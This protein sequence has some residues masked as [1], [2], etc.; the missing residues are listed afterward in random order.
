MST[1]RGACHA[2]SAPAVLRAEHRLLLGRRRAVAR[3]EVVRLT[4]F[5]R[6]VALIHPEHRADEIVWPVSHVS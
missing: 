4:D 2:G 6:Q 1:S 5:P 3:A